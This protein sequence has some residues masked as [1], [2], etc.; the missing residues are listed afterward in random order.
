MDAGF[1]EQGELRGIVGPGLSSRA[2][3]LPSRS[4]SVGPRRSVDVRHDARWAEARRDNRN[5]KRAL[6]GSGPGCRARSRRLP[7]VGGDARRSERAVLHELMCPHAGTALGAG[8][9]RR[10][11]NTE[12]PGRGDRFRPEGPSIDEDAES[13]IQTI[14]QSNGEQQ[15]AL[16]GQRRY[17]ARLESL[18]EAGPTHTQTMN[19]RR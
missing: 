17:L 5:A 19:V 6:P 11:R 7:A 2:P 18:V 10:A 12:C 9:N 1:S 8:A 14:V 3:S 4:L 16:R 13:L 15:I